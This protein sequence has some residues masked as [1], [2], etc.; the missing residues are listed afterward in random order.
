MDIQMKYERK[1]RWGNNTPR[2]IF[3]V[4]EITTLFPGA[5]F[6]VCVRDVRDFLRSYK[7]KWKTTEGARSARLK[8]LYHPVITSLLWKASIKG[9]N[10]H[11]LTDRM[12]LLRYEDLVTNT[13]SIVRQL[14]AFI[15]EDF[16]EPMLQVETNN[17]SIVDDMPNQK[18]IFSSSIGKWRKE[19][20]QEEI[21]LT[22][23]INRKE[24]NNLG[25]SLEKVKFSWLKLIM[26]CL[27]APLALWRG[28]SANKHKRGPLIKYIFKRLISLLKHH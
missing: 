7:T 9:I 23:K 4:N 25:Y 2:D 17:S 8:S 10:N 21:F 20:S 24:L 26:I 18:G 14:C 1:M 15:G 27:S 28:M 19:L 5:L 12:Y 3:Y 6:I 13:E 11:L 22:Q 16:E